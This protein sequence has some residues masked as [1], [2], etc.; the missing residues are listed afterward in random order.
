MS[1]AAPQSVAHGLRGDTPVRY[2]RGVGPQLAD[3]LARLEVR[4]LADLLFHLPLR[5]QD[6]S[7]V[8]PIG[9]LR[10]GQPAMIEA[11]VELADTVIRRRRVLLVRVHDGSGALTLRFFH[12]KQSQAEAFARGARLRCYGEVRSGAAG[13]E[14]VHPEYRILK[15]AGA[16]PE[17]TALTPIYPA[18]EG[19][20]QTKLRSL[21]GQ[22]LQWLSDDPAL[23]PDL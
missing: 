17:E 22:A 2:L 21:A 18:T 12:F 19:I 23:L 9:A 15:G 4:T 1:S 10:A 8:T 11:V 6:R 14:M 7:K 5:Y 3:K 16:P 13:L 20:G